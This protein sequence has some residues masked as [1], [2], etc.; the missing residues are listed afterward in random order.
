MVKE[1]RAEGRPAYP[2]QPAFVHGLGVLLELVLFS[3]DVCTLDVSRQVRHVGDPG[4]GPLRG[5]HCGVKRGW[6]LG[7]LRPA[8]KG[9]QQKGGRGRACSE[10][11]NTNDPPTPAPL[12]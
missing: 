8:R 5:W 4:Y 1:G 6:S 7:M 10:E 2:V 12:P 11:E 3:L 9:R